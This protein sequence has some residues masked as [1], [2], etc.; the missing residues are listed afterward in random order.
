MTDKLS[1]YIAPFKVVGQSIC[2]LDGNPVIHFPA[3]IEGMGNE[4]CDYLNSF[5]KMLYTDE[6]RATY[7]TCV[8]DISQKAKAMTPD[9]RHL[10]VIKITLKQTLTPASVSERIELFFL[11]FLMQ[12]DYK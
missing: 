11:N 6:E 10:R 3:K 5:Y 1:R 4:T 12:Y 9:E 2:T 7:I 8:N